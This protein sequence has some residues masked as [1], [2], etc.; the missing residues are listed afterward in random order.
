M[1]DPHLIEKTEREL[2]H[3]LLAELRHGPV[4]LAG[5]TERDVQKQRLLPALRQR[6]R[7]IPQVRKQRQRVQWAVF[8]LAAGMFGGGLL[9]SQ[10]PWSPFDEEPKV[11][12][13]LTA[14]GQVTLTQSGDSQNV[15]SNTVI[16]ANGTLDSAEAEASLTTPSGVRVELSRRTGVGLDGLNVARGD[17]HL[18]LL[19][20]RVDCTVP[21]LGPKHSFSVVTPS[22]TVVVH[23][24]RFS[25]RT[26]NDDAGH[27]RDG[28]CVEVSEG[29]VEVLSASGRR[30]LTAGQQWGCDADRGQDPALTD[31]ALGSTEDAHEL[32]REDDATANETPSDYPSRSRPKVTAARPP[33]Q[34]PGGTGK[35]KATAASDE[36]A[37]AGVG[38]LEQETR[39]LSRA[40]A[41][42]RRGNRQQA[43]ALYSQLLESYPSSPLAPEARKGH[44]RVR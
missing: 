37:M 31:D 15:R 42:E 33:E 4:P 27:S 25:V 3:Q 6:V 29:R 41:A 19:R 35:A 21:P 9:W 8:S 11:A 40:L 38:T 7:T 22:A 24:T 23:G 16:S 34:A 28:T 36:E 17:S 32:V 12:L 2:V 14:H 39:L 30:F 10:A 26:V 20:G 5:T 43:R 13:T 44:A 18:Q 1:T